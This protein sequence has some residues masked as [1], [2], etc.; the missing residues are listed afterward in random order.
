MHHFLSKRIFLVTAHPDDETYA[1]GSL[2]L[3]NKKYG[4][5]TILVCATLGEKGT[6]HLKRP[7]TARALQARRK[8]ELATAARLLAIQKVVTLHAPDGGVQK[9]QAKLYRQYLALARKFK[10]EVV[11]GFDETGMTGHWDH[12]AI[13]AVGRR[14]ARTLRLPYYTFAVSPKLRDRVERL[15]KARRRATTYIDRLRFATPT[16]RV[17]VSPIIKKKAIRAHASQ[18]DS[19]VVYAH[20]PKSVAQELLRVEYFRKV[21]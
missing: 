15:F 10:P 1:A 3:N 12:V 2:F 13:G 14:V 6:S 9:H 21:R 4:G 5:A 16:I 18:L 11:M 7:M 19:R 20:Y 8:R 17:A